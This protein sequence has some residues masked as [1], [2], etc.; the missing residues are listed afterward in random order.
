MVSFG[1]RRSQLRSNPDLQT[2]VLKYGQLAIMAN[3]FF[4]SHSIPFPKYFT[5]LK[6][7]TV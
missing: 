6:L 2:P 1:S 4:R 7:N 5:A 3:R